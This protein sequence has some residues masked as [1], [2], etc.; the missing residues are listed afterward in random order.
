MKGANIKTTIRVGFEEAIFGTQKELELPLKDECDVCKGTGSQPGHQ[1][2]VCGKCGGKGQI[3]TTQE[4]S[5]TYRPVRI[6]QVQERSS[7]I[8]AATVQAQD[9][10]RVERRYR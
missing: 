1:P 4:L 5:V 3:V 2:E 9:M 8:S 10:S 6:V 7:D